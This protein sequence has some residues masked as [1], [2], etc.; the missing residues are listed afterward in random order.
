MR[1]GRTTD[2]EW[3]ISP[4][5]RTLSGKSPDALLEFYPARPRMVNSLTF[6]LL[7]SNHHPLALNSP[8]R[9][10]RHNSGKMGDVVLDSKQFSKRVERIFDL[11]EVGH[12]D[13]SPQVYVHS[14]DANTNLLPLTRLNHHY[15]HV[16]ADRGLGGTGQFGCSCH[17]DGRA[18]RRGCLLHQNFGL[19]G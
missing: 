4:K 6:D 5:R 14:A 11:W 16:V 1:R 3:R 8:C 18:Q 10:H 15:D 12:R 17:I 7:P 13:F 2:G 19:A 9:P